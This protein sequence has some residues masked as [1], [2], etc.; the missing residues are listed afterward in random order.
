M[1]CG[2][3][4]T[5]SHFAS[6]TESRE[7]ND[8]KDESSD[9]C[10]KLAGTLQTWR[11]V[12]WRG[13]SFQTNAV[14]TGE[15][16]SS[17]VDI[18]VGRWGRQCWSDYTLWQQCTTSARLRTVSRRNTKHRHNINYTD[19]GAGTNLKVGDLSG[20]K[21][22][23]GALC[24]GKIFFGRA[25][26]FLALKTQS[27]VWWALSWWSVQFGQFLVC[28]SPTYGAR[29]TQPFVKVWGGHVPP[30]VLHGVGD[31]VYGPAG[32][33]CWQNVQFSS[34]MYTILCLKKRPFLYLE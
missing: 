12:T 30:P 8:W 9:D 25:L 3:G 32:C 19:S 10:R 13:S 23:G 18:H 14:A 34:E 11:D 2:V 28:C 26:H 6:T 22:G 33:Y 21:V 29:D 1:P 7:R 4:A 17:T 20:A 15:A 24:A 27:V 31:T 5:A 16:L